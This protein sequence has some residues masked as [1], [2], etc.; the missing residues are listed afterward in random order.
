GAAGTAGAPPQAASSADASAVPPNPRIIL[1]RETRADEIRPGASVDDEFSR[2][3]I[4]LTTSVPNVLRV[5]PGW[6]LHL[7][8]QLG[9]KNRCSS[10]PSL[11][12]D[13]RPVTRRS[14][15]HRYLENLCTSA[16]INPRNARPMISVNTVIA[17]WGEAGSRNSSMPPA[18]TMMNRLRR[19]AA[20]PIPGSR[21]ISQF[22]LQ[23]LL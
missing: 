6:K 8:L 13:A 23:S 20:L 11:T 1:R 3:S 5:V 10:H 4:E 14:H 18:S 16:T 22:F 15:S 12:K 7:F 19:S 21:F 9:C 17:N 2:L